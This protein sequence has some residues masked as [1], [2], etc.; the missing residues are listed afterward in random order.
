[1]TLRTVR[2]PTP[3]TGAFEKAEALVSA[4]FRQRLFD[5]SQ[6]KLEIAGE[7]YVLIRAS[8]LSVEF[9]GLVEDLYGPGREAEASSFS[10]NIL[11]DLAHALGRSDAADF[12]RKMGVD[13]PLE[14]LSAG[15]V[16]FAHA[17]WAF[18]DIHPDSNPSAGDDF[19]LLYD[20]PYSFEADAW[21]TRRDA[22]SPP[23]Q[24]HKTFPVCIMNAGYSSGWCEAAFDRVLV[25]VEV[26]CR[27]RG[28]EACRFIMAPPHRIEDHTRRFMASRPAPSATAPPEIP[29]FFSR[30]RVEEELRRSQAELERRVDE[31]TAE[32]VRAN[33]LLRRQML[34]REKI[35][36]QL[37]QAHK[38]EALGRLSGGIAHDFNNLLAILMTRATLLERRLAAH[39]PKG[40]AAFVDLAEMRKAGERATALTAQ[41]LAFSRGQVLGRDRIDL[42]AVVRDL[43]ATLVP[44]IGAD[45][46]LSL[47]A[48]SGGEATTIRADRGQ[49][50]QVVMNLVVNARDAMPSGGTLTLATGQ[51]RLE[52]PMRTLSGDLRPRSYALLTVADTGSGIDDETQSKMFD[53]FFTTKPEGKGTGLGLATVYGVVQQCDGGIVVDSAPGAGTSFRVYFPLESGDADLVSTKELSPAKSEHGT[54]TLLLVEDE[55]ELRNAVAEVLADAGYRVIAAADPLEALDLVE[56]GKRTVSLLVTD[57]V[58]PKMGGVELARR[59]MAA[60]AELRVLFVSGYAPEG[61]ERETMLVDDRAAFLAKPFRADELLRRVRFLLDR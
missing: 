49:I 20:H 18:V 21:L 16:H 35:A 33:S 38:L 5:P 28:D 37:R 43:A 60:R 7:R 19:F 57:L 10:R 2:V 40:D 27:A 6:G 42:T 36:K 58:M 26:L 51:V 53:P 56:S 52:A 22:E 1:M 41:L 24:R 15:P 50:E 23:A 59:L 3:M 30:K 4:Y 39:V 17:G 47:V 11:F 44:L 14:R 61:A 54:E 25:A 34:E 29:D 48:P 13:D 46:E 12:A 32:L 55:V 31:R 8:S 45:V 9:F